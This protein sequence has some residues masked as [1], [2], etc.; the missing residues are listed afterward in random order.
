MC[1]AKLQNA[2]QFLYI[3]IFVKN[4]CTFTEVKW[5]NEISTT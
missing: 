1:L 5:N 4:V 3:C 2:N